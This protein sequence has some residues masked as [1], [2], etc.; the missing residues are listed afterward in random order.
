MKFNLFL[1]LLLVLLVLY[2]RIHWQIQ[3][4]AHLPYVS[5]KSFMVL[6]LK[7]RW[8]QF[9]IHSCMW[10][11]VGVQ[12]HSCTCGN[13]VVQVPFVEETVLF[14]LNGLGILAKNQW[15]V[16]VWV[17]FQTLSSSPLVY[18]SIH[19]LVP[20]CFNYCSFAISFEIWKSQLSN[21]FSF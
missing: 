8:L 3:G 5:F 7:S 17:Y 11:G 16:D 14:Q 12:L 19:I 18:M 20:L 1:F 13:P 10:C 15:A 6:A 9:L 21:F 4:H 2:L